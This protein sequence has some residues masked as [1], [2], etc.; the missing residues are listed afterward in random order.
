MNKQMMKLLSG[1]VALLV[2][3]AVGLIGGKGEPAGA[4]S[5]AASVVAPAQSQSAQAQSAPGGAAEAGVEIQYT[6]RS[7][8]L[9]RSHYEK[10]GAEFG[11]ITQEEYLALANE[12]LASPDALRK[13]EKEDGDTVIYDEADNLFLILSTDGY[14]RT[15]FRPDDG[16]H[17]YER[18]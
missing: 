18:Q 2:L 8:K 17:Y 12:L 10:H 13:T 9:F 11:D 3:L 14:I 6:F 7:E 4:P 15:F 16:I 1:A 5:V